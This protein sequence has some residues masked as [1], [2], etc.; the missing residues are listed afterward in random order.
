M[1]QLDAST[2]DDFEP[3]HT[4]SV[5]RKRYSFNPAGYGVPW[6]GCASGIFPEV[7]HDTTNLTYFIL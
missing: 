4:E 7:S 6:Q 2:V 1:F 3:I 5:L